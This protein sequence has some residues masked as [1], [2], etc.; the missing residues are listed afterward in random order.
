MKIKSLGK[1]KLIELF[2]IMLRARA[3]DKKAMEL[4]T[5]GHIPGFIH[6]GI[7][8]EAIAAGVCANLRREDKICVTHRGH[9]QVI[10]KGV[11]L[12]QA[13]AELL[14]REDGFCRGKAGSIHLADV[15]MGVVGATGIVGA[16]IPLATGVACAAQ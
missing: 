16:G 5:A 9:S 10:A 14:G 2:T 11:D 8:Q 1:E 6:V 3:F 4:F 13:M 7:G 15:S 12:R